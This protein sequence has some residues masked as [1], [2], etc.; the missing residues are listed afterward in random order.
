[1]GY[2]LYVILDWQPNLRRF[3]VGSYFES[4][5]DKFYA[6][7]VFYFETDEA[8]CAYNPIHVRA[9][10]MGNRLNTSAVAEILLQGSRFVPDKLD[11]YGLIPQ[12]GAIILHA[13]TDQNLTELASEYPAALILEG[14]TV[15]QWNLE[16]DYHWGLA[17]VT[18][19]IIFKGEFYQGSPII[20]ISPVDVMTQIQSNHRMEALT[21]AIFGLSILSAQPIVKSIAEQIAEYTGLQETKDASPPQEKRIE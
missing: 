12:T 2:A 14:E 16:G 3:N 6:N 20:H 15:V 18:E 8:F 13:P 17:N 9:V 21:F 10:L 5:E 7:V 4:H 1:M 11:V 19:N